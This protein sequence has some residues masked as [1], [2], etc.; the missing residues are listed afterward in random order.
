[1]KAECYPATGTI[2][3]SW[4]LFS[5]EKI[6][7]FNGTSHTFGTLPGILMPPFLSKGMRW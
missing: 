3:V 7:L 4:L 6:R 5:L 1:M 2:R